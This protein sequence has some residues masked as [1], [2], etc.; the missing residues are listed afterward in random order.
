[1]DQE[2]AA[3][4]GKMLTHILFYMTSRPPYWKYDIIS[5]IWLH[6][7]EYTL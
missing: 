3:G 2:L 7:S 1:M 5:E 4:P 6:Q